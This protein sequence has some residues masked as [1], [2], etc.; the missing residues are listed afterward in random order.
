[1]ALT[2]TQLATAVADRAQLSQA[3]AKRAFSAAAGPVDPPDRA[4]H[5]I[6]A[7]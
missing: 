4:G 6:H 7:A 1:M 5:Y 2:Q 3:D